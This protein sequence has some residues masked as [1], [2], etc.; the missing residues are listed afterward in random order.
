VAG[1][2]K[3][4]PGHGRALADSHKELPTVTACAQELELDLAPFRALSGAGIAMTAHVRYTAW[5]AGPRHAVANR[6]GRGDPQDHR[7]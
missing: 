6:G 3:H 2:V 5:D 7:L 4:I 1:V